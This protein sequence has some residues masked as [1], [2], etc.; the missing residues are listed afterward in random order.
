M[1]QPRVGIFLSVL[2]RCSDN[3]TVLAIVAAL[4][5][6]VEHRTKQAMPWHVLQKQPTPASAT[7]LLDYITPSLPETLLQSFRSSH[8][9]VAVATISSLLIKLLTV[10]STGLLVLQITPGVHHD[11][12]ITASDDFASGFNPA[13]IGSTAVL[14]TLAIEN[15]TLPYEPGTTRHQ[16]FQTMNASHS[17]SNVHIDID[18]PTCHV[19]QLD[20]SQGCGWQ[21]GY[22]ECDFE[23][24]FGVECNTTTDGHDRNRLVFIYG[25]MSQN[26]SANDL[27]AKILPNETTTVV[28]EPKYNITSTFVRTDQNGNLNINASEMVTQGVASQPYPA[29]D[30]VEGLHTSVQAAGLI[31]GNPYAYSSV[32]NKPWYQLYMFF[33]SWADAAYPSSDFRDAQLL[34]T[35][36]NDLFAMVSAQ[37]AKQNLVAPSDT[38]IIGTCYSS[39]QRLRV[40]GLSLY[41]MAA[42]LVL[43]VL[44]TVI[45]LFNAPR[46]V[47]S[48][49]PASIGGMALIISES[50]S[51][52]ARLARNGSS[53]LDIIKKQLQGT[54]CRSVVS[55][56]GKGP[57]FSVEL[58]PCDGISY[59]K[60]GHPSVDMHAEMK[61]WRPLS[62]LPVFKLFVVALLLVLVVVLELLFWKS[63]RD[64]GLAKVDSQGYVRFSSVYVPAVVMLTAQTLVGMIAFSSVFIFPHYLLRTRAS[65]TRRDI[66]RDYVSQTA[67]QSVW[68]SAANRHLPV[69]F[70]ALAMLLTPLLTIAVSGLYTAQ[71]T[72]VEQIV[73]L[74]TKNQFNSSFIDDDFEDII[75]FEQASL[76][77][78]LLLTQ[79][80][81]FPLWT[82]DDIAL[83]QL[84]L[85]VPEDL[86]SNSSVLIG[87]NVTTSLPAI[88]A[89]LSCTVVPGNPANFQT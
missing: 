53:G 38:E 71:P 68:K 8:W 21:L 43:L 80:F 33:D 76:N 84:E 45:L 77:I 13:A 85:Q 70:M 35:A 50:P 88:R 30:L 2:A 57:Q 1:V 3:M 17:L 31:L 59:S 52:L 41:L 55:N 86:L 29:W 66:L 27:G 83:P 24:A 60:P 44:M 74:T 4:W 81:T 19:R 65:N 15:G 73:S 64:D 5:G 72:D 16:A 47:T 87:S 6:Q 51:I 89:E 9:P 12:K 36:A 32:A 26:V 61:W 49:D 25:R 7:L 14:S 37:M 42:A 48:R 34:E 54:Q 23:D 46:C 10:A 79:N 18:S 78:G 40:R 58:L 20:Y 63:E 75:P 56:N 69:F 82:Y 67:I 62:L 28:C 22:T 39:E 11:C